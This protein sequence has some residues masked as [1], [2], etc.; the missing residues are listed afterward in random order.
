MQQNPMPRAGDELTRGNTEQNEPSP[1]K[2][3]QIP[4]TD[5]QTTELMKLWAGIDDAARAELLEVIRDLI[6]QRH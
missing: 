6:R 1:Q 3:P 4:P 5:S 2:H